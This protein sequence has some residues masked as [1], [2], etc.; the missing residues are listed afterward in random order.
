[1]DART[2]TTTPPLK[3]NC[4]ATITPCSGYAS[5][6]AQS[7][8]LL[9]SGSIILW[10][11][12]HGTDFTALLGGADGPAGRSRRRRRTTP[13]RFMDIGPGVAVPLKVSGY[14]PSGVSVNSNSG[15]L[16]GTSK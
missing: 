15:A 6:T 11:D 2:S 3:R 1:M 14:L 9:T 8:A 5:M 13:K 7:T 4:S 12:F 16:N 10:N